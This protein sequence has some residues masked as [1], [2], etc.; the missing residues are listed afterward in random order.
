MQTT[1]A[2]ASYG[3][4]NTSLLNFHYFFSPHQTT[5]AQELDGILQRSDVAD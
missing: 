5:D 3:L 4:S 2:G 1:M